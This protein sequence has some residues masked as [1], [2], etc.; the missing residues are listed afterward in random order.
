[1]PTLTAETVRTGDVTLVEALVTAARPHRVR[2]ESRLDGP[3]WPPRSD[4]RPADGWDDRGVSTTVEA[5]TT[6]FGFATPAPPAEPAVELVAAEPVAPAS[7]PE[8]VAVLFERVEDRLE[9]AE[10]LASA[11][12]LPS[13]THA[14]AAAGGLAAVEE[15]AAE[16]ARDRRVVSRLPFAPEYLCSRLEAVDL[17]L[18]A[19]GRLAQTE[20]RSS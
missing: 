9:R 10:R 11:D 18:E 7:A 16:L 6:A 14:V 17:D 4:G 8:G 1:M 12:D 2:V 3:L 20:S 15:L 13:A 19:Y 5:G